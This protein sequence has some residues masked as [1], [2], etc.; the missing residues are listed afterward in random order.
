MPTAARRSRP[1][2]R[3]GGPERARGFTLLEVL[4]ALAIIAVAL[5]AA[6]RGAMALTTNA[7]DV[8]LKLLAILVAQNQLIELRLA[9]NQVGPGESDYDCPQGGFVFHCRQSISATPN[10]F[11]RR[12]EVRVDGGAENP[13]QLADLMALL[14]VN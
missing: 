14:P 6:L 4:V 13:R 10:P 1:S 3:A 2:G 7:R 12:A 9:H 11:F 8:D 5:T